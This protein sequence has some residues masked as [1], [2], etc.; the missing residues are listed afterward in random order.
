[1]TRG[2]PGRRGQRGTRFGGHRR[3]QAH[4]RLLPQRCVRR[5]RLRPDREP[6]RPGGGLRHFGREGLLAGEEQLGCAIW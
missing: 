1:M 4:L 3:H 6:R 5:L 2:P